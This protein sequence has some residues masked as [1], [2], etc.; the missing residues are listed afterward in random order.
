MQQGIGREGLVV[1]ETV[2][3]F[4]ETANTPIET[5][6]ADFF[7]EGTRMGWQKLDRRVNLARL[8]AQVGREE[9]AGRDRKGQPQNLAVKIN[10]TSPAQ[11]RGESLF[12]HD[13]RVH[14][15]LPRLKRRLS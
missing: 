7:E 12:A 11:G 2:K 10:P 13:P 3:C 15:D 6:G 4:V 1:D 5:A 14:V 9:G 8:V